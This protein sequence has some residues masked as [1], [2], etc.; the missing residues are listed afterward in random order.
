MNSLWLMVCLAALCL[1]HQLGE[2]KIV[3]SL[4]L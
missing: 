3:A 2:F 1:L 4:A